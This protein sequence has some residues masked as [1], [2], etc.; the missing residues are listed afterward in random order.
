MGSKRE[1]LVDKQVIATM[2][3]VELRMHQPKAQDVA[4]VCDAPWEGNTSGYFTLFQD[5]DLYR[6]YY[7]GSHHAGD[8]GKPAHE[9]TTCY[10][11]SRDGITWTKPKLGLVE[12]DG[13]K[14]NN[15]ILMGEGCSNFSPFKD[16]SPNCPPESRYKALAST[17]DERTRKKRPSLQAY[18]SADGIRW[19][20]IREEP[21]IT[22]GSFDS[23]NTA[24]YDP[25]LGAY[26]AY[27]RYFTGG[28]TDERGWKP[29]GVRAIRTATSKDFLHWESQADLQ[30]GEAPVAQLYTNAVRP[31]ARAPH[32]LLGFPTRYQPKLSQ[33]E[34]VLMTSRDGV[35]FQRWPDPLIPITAPKDRDGNR[36]NYM[37]LGILQLPGNDKEVS[38][39][40]SEAYYKGPGSRIRR[41]TFRV[42]G[43]V[44]ASAQE[45]GELI[46]KPLTFVGEKLS[47][48]IVSKGDTRVEVQDAHGKA[49]PGFSLEDCTP[50]RG[51]FTDHTIAWKGGSLA[52]LQGKPIRLRLVLR[53]A[54]L[55]ALQFVP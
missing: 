27:W 4:L 5:G 16:T 51:D 23:Q 30:Y 55:F 13:S 1:L 21:V 26:R 40:A 10:A 49:I 33:V 11:E 2:E 34:P 17:G 39:F 3:G 22:A 52:E 12:F 28:Y 53:Q 41:F 7:R 25:V 54:D 36:S 8:E 46:T 18:Q 38:V 24:F 47:L 48:N 32:L 42:D 19:T 50:I 31:Y 44:S 20:R 43:F 35:N 14:E 6:V 29:K 45:G 9:L 15:I 37:T